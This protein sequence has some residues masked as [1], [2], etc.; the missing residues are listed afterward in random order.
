MKEKGLDVIT[1]LACFTDSLNH[2]D[3]NKIAHAWS[4]PKRRKVSI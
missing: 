1:I 2:L 4:L 3:I